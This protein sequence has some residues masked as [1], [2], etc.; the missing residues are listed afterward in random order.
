MTYRN[1]LRLLVG[2]TALVVLLSGC[3][4]GGNSRLTIEITTPATRGTVTEG[5]VLVSGVISDP[6]ATVTINDEEIDLSSDGA[7][8]LTVPL[9]YGQNRIIIRAEKEGSNSAQR[10]IALT[11]ALILTVEE[12]ADQSEIAGNRVTIRGTISDPTARVT[13]TGQDIVVAPDGGFSYDVDLYYLETV[14]NV[15]AQV[16]DTEPVS[17]FVTV[18]RATS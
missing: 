10:S 15:T 6:E 7:Y 16:P 8:N 11:R 4:I 3:G 17:Q 5:E 1:T 9:A 14:L 12:P 18:R 13:V 2:F